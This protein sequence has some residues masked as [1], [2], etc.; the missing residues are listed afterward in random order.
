MLRFCESYFSSQL[1][2]AV[3]DKIVGTAYQ[4]VERSKSSNQFVGQKCSFGKI[5]TAAH[6]RPF[7]AQL[8]VLFLLQRYVFFLI[9]KVRW[10][11]AGRGGQGKGFCN[12]AEV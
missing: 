8:R 2:N 10:G 6:N 3:G 7:S 12:G 11:K 5:E 4:V 9:S 1:Q